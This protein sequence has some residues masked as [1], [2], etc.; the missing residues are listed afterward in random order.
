MREESL[1]VRSRSLGRKV[2]PTGHKTRAVGQLKHH[3]E[4]NQLGLSH[5]AGSCPGD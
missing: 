1:E 3:V 4:A 2:L 5:P